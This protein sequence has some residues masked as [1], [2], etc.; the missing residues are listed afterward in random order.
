M[1]VLNDAM[2]GLQDKYQVEF[3]KYA[4]QAMKIDDPTGFSYDPV[5]KRR[6]PNILI[7]L[8]NTL[9]VFQEPFIIAGY[10]LGN[11]LYEINADSA[12][13]FGKK[14]IEREQR[15]LD[16]KFI[17]GVVMDYHRASGLLQAVMKGTHTLDMVAAAGA[18]GVADVARKSQMRPPKSSKDRT[19]RV[20][21]NLAP[22][23]CD[24][25]KQVKDYYDGEHFTY[26][27]S[28]DKI[29]DSCNC[30]LSFEYN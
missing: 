25:C 28:F 29:H 21:F 19:T 9:P 10:E 15:S 13:L 7:Y 24:F 5:E 3:K 4:E 20:K 8:R 18:K 11:T 30:T 23:A 14:F 22:G 16:N 1:S 6:L 26:I 27:T 2:A 12:K 17:D